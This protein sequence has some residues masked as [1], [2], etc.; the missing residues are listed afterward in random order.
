M[1]P[2]PNGIVLVIMEPEENQEADTL[3]ELGWHIRRAMQGDVSS[4]QVIRGVPV[5][6]MELAER[7]YS[8]H[9][10]GKVLQALWEH[11]PVEKIAKELV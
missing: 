8:W 10:Q 1:R 6:M 7:F 4:A 2:I 3:H 11:W 9:D 5:Y